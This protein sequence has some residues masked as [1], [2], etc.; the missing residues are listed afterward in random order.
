MNTFNILS[1]DGGGLRGIVPV[2]IL[3]KLE[4]DTGKK[5]HE[6]FDMIAGTS[7]GG[8]IAAFLTLKDESN[9]TKPKYGLDTLENIYTQQGGVI[10]PLAGN[11]LA[12]WL[13]DAKSYF[14]P[15]F[16]DAG[17][18]KVLSQY[19]SQGTN[20]PRL[21]DALL[22]I[23]V[24]TYNLKTN[25]PLFFKSSE[26]I[27][28]PQANAQIFD[29]CRATSAA[30][31]YLPAYSFTYK[32]Q[33]A[34]CI[35]GGVYVN[36][37]T[38]AAIAEIKKYGNSGFYKKRDGSPVRDLQE[39]K[40]LSLGTGSYTGDISEQQAEHWGALAW[41]THVIDIMMKGVSQSIDYESKEMMGLQDYLRVNINIPDK[42]FDDMA[43]ASKETLLYLEDQVEKQV[44]SN[45]PLMQQ[46]KNLVS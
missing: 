36:N 18:N 23:L 13:R 20:A 33:L 12:Q 39:V 38:M 9:P 8:L 46:I 14:R 40:V 11:K 25:E 6:L 16:S 7:T 29:V 21:A 26:A 17:I 37:P 4:Q 1:I 31:T 22:P 5:V 43:D 27:G 3:M 35:D 34:T 30:P 10:F 28:D 19:I 44:T 24:S 45:V 15:E 42:K 32:Q 2:Q 41:V